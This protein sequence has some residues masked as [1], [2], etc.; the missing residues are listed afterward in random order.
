M[1]AVSHSG[2]VMSPVQAPSGELHQ[3]G[4]CGACRVEDGG[5]GLRCT[6]EVDLRGRFCS[7]CRCGF[8]WGVGWTSGLAE[9]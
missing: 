2:V 1:C 3:R 4:M 6:A 9:G 7:L 8:G 5:P